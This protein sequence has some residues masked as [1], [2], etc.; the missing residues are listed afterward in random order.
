MA[1]TP[2]FR[3]S[4]TAIITPFTKTGIDYE[5][6]ERNIEFQYENGT[7][8][9]VAC[10][11]TGENAT[12]TDGDIDAVFRAIGMPRTEAPLADFLVPLDA[13]RNPAVGSTDVG[14]VSWVV[15]TVQAHAP[16][17][18]IGTPFHTWQVVAQ[19]KTPA[20]AEVATRVVRQQPRKQTRS[21][22]KT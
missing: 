4:C 14:D 9:V 16:T 13:P 7:A 19:G 1:K 21:Q 11:T 15:P 17:V 12:L 18:A 20:A 22:R 10:G 5:R 2:L 3:G 8:A 6:L